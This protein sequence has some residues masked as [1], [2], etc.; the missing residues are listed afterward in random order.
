MWEELTIAF[1]II[2]GL[3]LF[4]YGVT[5]LRETLG[6]ISGKRV[7]R[8]LEKVSKFY[9]IWY[10]TPEKKHV[11]EEKYYVKVNDAPPDLEHRY[12]TEDI[13]NAI[14]PMSYIADVAGIEVP[15][16]KTVVHYQA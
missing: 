1:N 6:K 10:G 3:A 9:E 15:T 12:L 4:M 5:L 14:V 8:I 13:M 11:H 16:F 7:V 2:G